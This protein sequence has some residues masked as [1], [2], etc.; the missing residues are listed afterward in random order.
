MTNDQYIKDDLTQ[1]PEEIAK[2][3]DA[4]AP[5]AELDTETEVTN[6]DPATVDDT[7]GSDTNPDR[8][9]ENA[10]LTILDDIIGGKYADSTEISDRLD[11]AANTLEKLGMM[12]LYDERLNAAA[13][14][15]TGVLKTEAA[16]V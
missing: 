14:Y 2:A 12:D 9:E 4:F 8:A 6:A 16:G 7:L 1:T 5:V 15:L 3:L 13:D 11:E 10:A